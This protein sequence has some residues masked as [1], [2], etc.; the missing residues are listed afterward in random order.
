MRFLLFLTSLN[1]SSLL[2]FIFSGACR[3]STSFNFYF[4][5]FFIFHFHFSIVL[6]FT[7]FLYLFSLFLHSFFCYFSGFILFL[8]FQV[9]ILNKATITGFAFVFILWG[10]WGSTFLLFFFISRLPP[11]PGPSKNIFLT[12]LQFHLILLRCSPSF[13][14]RIQCPPPPN[15]SYEL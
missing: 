10:V 8:G 14:T 12:E 7:L 4:F 5:S 6:Y 9:S 15:R 13:K 2:I 11:P 1:Y 3:G